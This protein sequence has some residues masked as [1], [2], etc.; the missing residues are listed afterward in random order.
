MSILITGANGYISRCLDE[1]LTK[2]S[3]FS[4]VKRVSVRNGCDSFDIAKGTEAII[5]TAALVH[6]KESKYKEREYFDVNYSLTVQLANKA[7]AAGVKQ[8]V[9]LST[10]AVFNQNVHV[11]RLY[12]S[13]TPNPTTLYGRSKLAAEKEL[14]ALADEN[15]TV[16]IVRPPMVYGPG[17]PGN[18]IQLSKLAKLTP[19]FP[20]VTNKRSMIFIDHLTELIRQI[21]INRDSGI[22]HPQDGEYICTTKMV[23]EIASLHNRKVFVSKTLAILLIK[24]FGR[25][26]IVSKVFGNLTYS[27]DMS[28]YRDN[29]YQRLCFSETIKR[30]ESIKD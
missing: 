15:F 23:Q 11:G 17:C 22:F 9:F 20:N 24:L 26:E 4:N 12:L 10:M 5:H 2:N 14:L 28:S 29:S 21:I 16:S 19:I 3:S 27:K 18:Y 7:K 8:F 30:T 6:K 13:T 25:T 1:W